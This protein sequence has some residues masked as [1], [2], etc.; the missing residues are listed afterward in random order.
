MRIVI[1]STSLFTNRFFTKSFFEA[2][3][4]YD[5]LQ[6]EFWTTSE[7]Q[8]PNGEYKNLIFRSFP[9]VRNNRERIN[10][11]R[12]IND[13]AWTLKLNA[14]SI[15]SMNNFNRSFGKN[16]IK[17]ILT[18]FI[19]KAIYSLRLYRILDRVVHYLVAHQS[20]SPE[21][22]QLLSQ[23]KPDVLL[24]TNPFWYHETAIAVE[25]QKLG[26]KIMSFIPSWDN[27]T[28]KSRMTFKSD[29][30]FVWSEI[31]KNELHRFYPFTKNKPVISLGALQ[32]EWF[33][34]GKFY[35]TKEEFC[36][37]YGLHPEKKIIL[38]TTGSPNFI[39]TEYTGAREFAGKFKENFD[40]KNTQLLIRPHPNKDNNE[41]K[42][43][44]DRDNGVF[45]HYTINS[46]LK[47][48]SR[49]LN[50]DEI[51]KWINTFRYVDVV[52]NLSSTVI[53]DA[54]M[55]DVPVININYDPSPEK[56]YDNFIK[57]I[58]ST[59][60]HLKDIYTCDG[61]PQASNFDELVKWTQYFLE[62]PK[63]KLSL[64]KALFFKVCGDPKNAGKIFLDQIAYWTKSLYN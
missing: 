5:N 37:L 19:G 59:W 2:L 24:V 22:Y 34:E 43:I 16:S 30:Y 41:L 1:L 12:R 11:L 48:E 26:I 32:Y 18:H 38:Y 14:T 60:T 27:I 6:L 7:I 44:E 23:N 10:I 62:N 3:K 33:S 29:L 40:I 36:K 51:L 35:L 45:V 57:E 21:S 52:I 4:C 53:F 20:R 47:T 64:R 31:R 42:E 8:Y 50:L 63:D 55:F 46:G 54:L 49:T 39:E 56:A 13:W 28:T 9:E 17:S 58:N 61:I 25:A 15:I